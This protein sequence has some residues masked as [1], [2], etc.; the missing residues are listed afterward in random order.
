MMSRRS[1]VLAVVASVFVAVSAIAAAAGYRVGQRV[2][3]RD[4]YASYGPRPGWVRATIVKDNGQGSIEQYLIRLDGRTDQIGA[5]IGM[6]RPADGSP[7][8]PMP[9]TDPFRLSQLYGFHQDH[10]AWPLPD[11]APPA[12]SSGTT[13]I[14]GSVTGTV[15]APAGRPG[16]STAAP[17][18]GRP[19]CTVGFVT[20]AGALNYDARIVSHDPARG[21]Y[22]VVF[23]TGYPG[24]EE[25]LVASDLK[26]CAGVP[27]PPVSLSFFAG[28][29]DMFTGG[30]GAWQRKDAGSDWHIRALEGAKAPPLTI[31]ADGSYTWVIDSQ[32]TVSGQ[33]HPAAAGELKYGYDKRGTTILLVAGED[34][35][36]W[37][38]SRDT[39][40]TDDG[41]D[42][43]L[44]ERRDLGLTYRA[45]RIR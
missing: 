8:P 13:G 45:S 37:L 12:A 11:D 14:R 26:S 15:S 18:N 30:G 40:G 31:Q 43:V 42:R 35:K 17:A 39:T 36:D 2:F 10:D 33:W 41:R 20:R 16:T 3:W 24:D 9:T 34:G 1:V 38:V 5:R 25:W 6:L 32:T 7:R 44:I 28:T 22:R 29:W 4:D 23:V 27:P 21:L 19:P